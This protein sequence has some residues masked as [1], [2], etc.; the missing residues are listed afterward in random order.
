METSVEN[1]AERE[2]RFAE[3]L[4]ADGLRLTHQR[5]EVIRELAGADDHPDVD[6]LWR[7]VRVRVPTIS[8]D[9]VYRT[10][11]VLVERHLV[12]RISMPRAT[13]FDPDQHSH[14][15]FLCDRCG[16]LEDVSEDLVPSP[17][18]PERLT[19]IGDIQ[20][21]HLEL[22]GVCSTCSNGD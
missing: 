13:R 11:G 9:T 20:S 8:E 16:R 12:E 6:T 14:H 18:V 22:R 4:R 5:L 2:A 15:H 7:R 19:G 17:P 10:I 3:A 21:A 1:R